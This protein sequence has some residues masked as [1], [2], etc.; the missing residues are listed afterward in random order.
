M[1]NFSYINSKKNLKDEVSEKLLY[2]TGESTSVEDSQK[3]STRNDQ[4]RVFP[5]CLLQSW[6][7]SLVPSYIYFRTSWCQHCSVSSKTFFCAN[8]MQFWQTCWKFFSKLILIFS[9][10]EKNIR[11]IFQKIFS[12][13]TFIGKF[14]SRIPVFVWICTSLLKTGLVS[15]QYA[16]DFQISIYIFETILT[17]VDGSDCSTAAAIVHYNYFWKKNPD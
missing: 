9:N 1:V 10:S 14:I 7:S 11:I 5:Q 15:L 16:C 13:R 3:L 8:S 2:T 6:E 12:T 17:P 4:H